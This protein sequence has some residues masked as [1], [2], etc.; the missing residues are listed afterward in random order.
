MS[1]ERITVRRDRMVLLVRC[2][3]ARYADCALASRL[4]ELYPALSSHACV[5]ERGP[6]FGDVMDC[7]P[8]PHLLEHLVIELQGD[9]A[10]FGGNALSDGKA[11]FDGRASSGG[12]LLGATE[13]LDES[14]GLARV[15]MSYRDDMTAM[16][17]LSEALAVLNDIL[18]DVRR[19]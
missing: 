17:A 7:T 10:P 5:N 2:R 3:G 6:R 18:R 14:A 4:R 8:L 9:A 11:S 1:V 19:N 16:R 12:L 13:W 15:Q